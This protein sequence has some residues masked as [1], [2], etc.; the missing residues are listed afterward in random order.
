MPKGIPDPWNAWDEGHYPTDTRPNRLMEHQLDYDEHHWSPYEQE[1]DL[2]H[3]EEVVDEELEE[4]TRGSSEAPSHIATV[5]SIDRHKNV[6]IWIIVAIL[7]GIGCYCYYSN[8][9][10]HG[11]A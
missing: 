7:I 10:K 3:S 2:T 8:H 1:G 11:G 6:Y 9:L 5:Q 4:E